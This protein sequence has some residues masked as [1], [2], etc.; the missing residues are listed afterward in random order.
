MYYRIK[1][2]EK[3]GYSYY[4]SIVKVAIASYKMA[5]SVYPNP[6]IGNQLAVLL[7]NLPKGTYQLNILNTTGLLVYSKNIHHLGGSANH[8]IQLNNALQ[9][10]G[11]YQLILV[12][13]DIKL[14]Q[15]YIKQ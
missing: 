15:S 13:D 6:A 12:K 10:S 4:S 11:M 14:I 8:Q 5:V 7:N 2:I 1:V 3:S 9:T